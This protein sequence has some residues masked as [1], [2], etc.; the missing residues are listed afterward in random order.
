ML[1]MLFVL[2][3]VTTRVEKSNVAEVASW[4]ITVELEGSRLLER[5]QPALNM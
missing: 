5:E 1:S 2:V 3:T 4:M